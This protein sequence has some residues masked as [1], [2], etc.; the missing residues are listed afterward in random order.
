MSKDI[1]F[2]YL[3]VYFSGIENL[4][5]VAPQGFSADLEKA[6]LCTMIVTKRNPAEREHFLNSLRWELGEGKIR[7]QII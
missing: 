3:L 2:C 1:D 5:T 4:K 6:E 7:R